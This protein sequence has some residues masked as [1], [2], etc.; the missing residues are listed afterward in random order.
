MPDNDRAVIVTG[1]ARGI[2]RATASLLASEGWR[3][4]AVDQDASALAALT[5]ARPD[6]EQ[7]MLPVV[8]DVSDSAAVRE[9]VRTAMEAFG[10]IDVL[11]NNAGI[12]ADARLETMS[13][14][15]F[16]RVLAVNLK[17]VYACTQAVAPHM[18]RAKQGKIINAAS[19]VGLHGNFGQTNYAAAKGGVIAM[20]KTWAKELGPLGITANAVAPG[21]IVTE[22][23][24][25]VPAKVL[26]L[27]EARTPLRRLGQPEDVARVYA[28]LAS[29]AADYINGQVIVVDGGMST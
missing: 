23:T 3:V 14:A 19:T 16:D 18:V 13:E 25:T 22:M 2:G 9:M 24:A 4:A 7:T 11:I 6:A 20:T 1:A 26:A 17:G 29:P 27:A 21:F 12:T 5:S 10:H 8:A 15:Q 28:F